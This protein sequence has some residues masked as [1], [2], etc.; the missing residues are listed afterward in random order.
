MRLLMKICDKNRAVLWWSAHDQLL[1]FAQHRSQTSYCHVVWGNRKRRSV[2]CEKDQEGL[3]RH[4]ETSYTSRNR[5]G[6]GGA[7]LAHSPTVP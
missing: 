7:V 4:V 3:L 5:R 2:Q 1:L 6:D